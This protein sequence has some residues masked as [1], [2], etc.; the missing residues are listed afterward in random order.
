[1]KMTVKVKMSN[2]AFGDDDFEAAQELARILREA[3]DKL[4]RNGLE[5]VILRDVNGNKV[6]EVSFS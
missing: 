1:M 5:H 2:S 4:E 3:A 6:G